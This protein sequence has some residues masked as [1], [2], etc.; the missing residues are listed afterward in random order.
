MRISVNESDPGYRAYHL[1]LKD[2]AVFE[3]KLNGVEIGNVTTADE[4]KGFVEV[5]KPG[6][7]ETNC[8]FGAVEIKI[9]WPWEA[10]EKQAKP[11]I[12]SAYIDEAAE[13]RADHLIDAVRYFQEQE[14]GVYNPD[15]RAIEL[16]IDQTIPTD[17]TRE[18][19]FTFNS[20][21]VENRVHA[22]DWRRD[23]TYLQTRAREISEARRV[24]ANNLRRR[25][26]EQ[27]AARPRQTTE[28]GYRDVVRGDNGNTV[29]NYLERNR[30]RN[31]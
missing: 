13:I 1:G 22:P 10:K 18:I 11:E 14:R 23:E 25:Q 16:Q 6:S 7:F 19:W 20:S 21:G 2:G 4:V 15:T 3:V 24:A 9:V 12:G 8:L 26:E 17:R 31:R 30:G 28:E 27:E 5:Y 29:W